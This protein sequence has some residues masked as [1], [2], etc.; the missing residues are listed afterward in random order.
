MNIYP[1]GYSLRL[2]N[3]EIYHINEEIMPLFASWQLHSHPLFAHLRK[4]TIYIKSPQICFWSIREMQ[5]FIFSSVRP[6]KR[7]NAALWNR[8]SSIF[9]LTFGS[10]KK[11]RM[12]YILYIFNNFL[13]IQLILPFIMR[14]NCITLQLNPLNFF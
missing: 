7:N 3:F 14:N 4:S 10:T 1:I 11:E 13:K 8:L 6:F 5:R 9:D 2:Q 12:P